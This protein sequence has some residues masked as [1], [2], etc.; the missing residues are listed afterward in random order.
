[1]TEDE[2]LERFGV[3]PKEKDLDQIRSV[4][5]REIEKEQKNQGDGDTE[6]MRLCCVQ[7]FNNGSKADIMEIWNAKV[8]SM[9]TAASIDIQLLCGAGY[10]ETIEYLKKNESTETQNAFRK[11]LEC[12]KSGD[13]EDYSVEKQKKVYVEYYIDEP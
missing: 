12:R 8:A 6:L 11:L 5:R 7:L 13:F 3:V 10:D 2:S 4:L 1:M 9:D